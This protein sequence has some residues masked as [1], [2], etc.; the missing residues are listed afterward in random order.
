VQVLLHLP[1]HKALPDH[2]SVVLQTVN[3]LRFY[4]TQGVWY[5]QGFYILCTYL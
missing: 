2:M 4:R 5:P 3:K 1:L